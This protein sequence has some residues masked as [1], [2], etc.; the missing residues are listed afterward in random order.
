MIN[1]CYCNNLVYLLIKTESLNRFA[2]EVK[3]KTFI[4]RCTKLN[5]FDSHK[6]LIENDFWIFLYFLLF[7]FQE[8]TKGHC[9]LVC[10][11]YH[12]LCFCKHGIL[13]DTESDGS[14]WQ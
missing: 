6:Q 7:S 10:P 4:L 1:R 13:Y 5:I 9:N 3:L 2:Y 11:C 14:S 8:F 12:G